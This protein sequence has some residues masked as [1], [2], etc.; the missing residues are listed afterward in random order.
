MSALLLEVR[1]TSMQRMA[2]PSDLPNVQTLDACLGTGLALPSLW[3]LDCES[4]SDQT[5]QV[6]AAAAPR[7]A[8]FGLWPICDDSTRRA[9]SDVG[10]HVC[11]VVWLCGCVVVWFCGFVVVWLCGCVVVR[12]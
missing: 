6:L 2:C 9:L 11:L 12:L 7:L 1:Q 10:T 5:V 3:N 4:V 8:V